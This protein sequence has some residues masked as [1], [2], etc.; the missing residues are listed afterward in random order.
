MSATDVEGPTAQN[1]EDFNG[2]LI[3]DEVSLSKDEHFAESVIHG[4]GY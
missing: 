4:G 3:I 1:S 2:D